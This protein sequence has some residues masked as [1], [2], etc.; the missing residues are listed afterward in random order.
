MLHYKIDAM[1][2]YTMV[3]GATGMFMAWELLVLAL[4]GWA[5]RKERKSRTPA[6]A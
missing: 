5:V 2:L 3:L 1:P 4:K 6:Y